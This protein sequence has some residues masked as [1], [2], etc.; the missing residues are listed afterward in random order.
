MTQAPFNIFHI[1]LAGCKARWVASADNEEAHGGAVGSGCRSGRVGGDGRRRGRCC[2]QN[3]R[4]DGR[5]ET[6]DTVAENRAGQADV[7]LRFFE[8]WKNDS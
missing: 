1:H 7:F 8:R 3:T 6:V 2:R 5:D 4:H